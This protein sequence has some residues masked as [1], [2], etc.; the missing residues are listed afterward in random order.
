MEALRERAGGG[1]S[2]APGESDPAL[3][4]LLGSDGG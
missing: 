1:G 3:E 2:P 4:Y